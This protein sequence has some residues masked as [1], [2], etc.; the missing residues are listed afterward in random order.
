MG[1]GL[2]QPKEPPARPG[3]RQHT[4]PGPGSQGWESSQGM[5]QPWLAS[6]MISIPGPTASRTA[7]TTA[8]SSE[9]SS[10]WNRILRALKPLARSSTA[11]AALF[12]GGLELSGGGRRP[13]S[14]LCPRPG[15]GPPVFPAAFPA[16]SHRA[17]SQGPGAAVVKIKVVQNLP[18]ALNVQGV[19]PDEQV[20]VSPGSRPSYPRSPDR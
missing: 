11:W 4:G 8:R 16:R 15:A 9:R 3:R 2:L 5:R 14:C 19:A 6:T 20:L 17:R 18:V 1:Q 7:R 13:G 10:L 12:L